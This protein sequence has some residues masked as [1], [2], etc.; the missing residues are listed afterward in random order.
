MANRR[1]RRASSR[2]RRRRKIRNK[3]LICTS[4]ECY[5]FFSPFFLGQPRRAVV[6][7]TATLASLINPAHWTLAVASVIKRATD[8]RLAR[9]GRRPSFLH[10]FALNRIF[11]S[12]ISVCFNCYV[13]LVYRYVVATMVA[14][15]VR[16]FCVCVCVCMC[17]FFMYAL[18]EFST[19]AG[20][21]E[22]QLGLVSC[23]V[24][25]RDLAMCATNLKIMTT[26]TAGF[27]T[28][29]TPVFPFP[30]PSTPAVTA[31]PTPA[32]TPMIFFE[33]T[34]V[35]ASMQNG[36]NAGITALIVIII[37][38]TFY[39]LRIGIFCDFRL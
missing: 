22:E 23:D 21:A 39:S 27:I 38:V 1:A 12:F 7:T 28:E 16:L 2:F 32:P 13:M 11:S 37:L 33:M 3:L 18:G 15:F 36:G 9:F 25:S 24:I 31:S 4:N 8:R 20:F 26:A 19:V 35:G 30:A 10:R 14:L 34:S 6:A 29:T 5:R 17:E